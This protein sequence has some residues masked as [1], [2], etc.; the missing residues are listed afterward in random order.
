MAEPMVQGCLDGEEVWYAP[1]F[2]RSRTSLLLA[3]AREASRAALAATL[4]AKRLQQIAE[5]RTDLNPWPGG[6]APM[7]PA[8][9]DFQVLQPLLDH[10]NALL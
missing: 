9:V 3:A 2:S 10:M 5:H 7:A 1:D 4:A 8:A 6:I